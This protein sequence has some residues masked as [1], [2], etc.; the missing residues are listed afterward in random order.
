MLSAAN[1]FDTA[2]K[3]SGAALRRMLFDLWPNEAREARPHSRLHLRV[4]GIR[5]PATEHANFEHV[6][7]VRRN[8]RHQSIA[9]A[10]CD[11]EI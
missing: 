2:S 7:S 11:L 9:T 3:P 6:V 5:G 8:N 4:A 10:L 1:Y